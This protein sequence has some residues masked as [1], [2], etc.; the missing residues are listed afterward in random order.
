MGIELAQSG[1][2]A[3][4]LQAAFE[5]V[6]LHG[7]FEP[8]RQLLLP[9]CKSQHHGPNQADGGPDPDLG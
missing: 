4:Q 3:A 1:E 8:G 9:P 2:L 7:S 5:L 6:A